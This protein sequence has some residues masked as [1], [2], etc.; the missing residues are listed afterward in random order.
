MKKLGYPI[1]VE[2][3]W[4][5]LVLPDDAELKPTV[6]CLKFRGRLCL[7]I[8][9]VDGILLIIFRRGLQHYNQVMPLD[10]PR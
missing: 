6:F 7:S 2:V 10:F 1:T 4:K 3:R 9:F 8:L 5:A